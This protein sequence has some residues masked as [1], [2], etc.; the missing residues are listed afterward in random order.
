VQNLTTARKRLKSKTPY[1]LFQCLVVKP[2]EHQIPDIYKLAKVYGIDEV[3]LKTAQIYNYKEGSS[4]IP[5]Q[6]I[7]SRYRKN[8]D[9]SYSLKNKLNNHCWKLWHS[10]VITWDGKVVP[11]C[12]DKDAHHV[13][14]ELENS[15]LETVWNNQAYT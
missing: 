5:E 15:D 11:C 6:E 10:P 4:L 13:L 14:G 12:F 9:G 2:N 7:Y 3:K 8:E 1:L